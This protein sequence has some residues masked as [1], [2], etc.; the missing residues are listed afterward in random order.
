MGLATSFSASNSGF[1]HTMSNSKGLV[2]GFL[3]N[4]E[5]RDQ[6][7]DTSFTRSAVPCRTKDKVLLQ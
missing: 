6:K 4:P 5:V 2:L 3:H 1:S 7:Y